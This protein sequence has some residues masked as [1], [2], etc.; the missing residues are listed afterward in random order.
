MKDKILKT[1]INNE[2]MKREIT[3]KDRSC[4]LKL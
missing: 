4:Y 2:N 3:Y 1:L